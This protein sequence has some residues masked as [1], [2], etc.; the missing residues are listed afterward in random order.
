MAQEPYTSMHSGK[1]DILYYIMCIY[2]KYVLLQLK[3][4][5]DYIAPQSQHA[6]AHARFV[7]NTFMFSFDHR[8]KLDTRPEWMGW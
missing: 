7:E 5:D 6:S 2:P 4:D 8:S 3:N 1:L